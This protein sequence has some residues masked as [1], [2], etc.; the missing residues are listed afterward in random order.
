MNHD[1]YHIINF[2]AFQNRQLNATLELDKEEK[3]AYQKKCFSNPQIN[4][5]GQMLNENHLIEQQIRYLLPGQLIIFGKLDN[6]NNNGRSKNHFVVK[7]SGIVRGGLDVE[8]F[9]W[10]NLGK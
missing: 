8:S 5:Q 1:F 3:I 6:N 10:N 7:T 9:V 4:K 2:W